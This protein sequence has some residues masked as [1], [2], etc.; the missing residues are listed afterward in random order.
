MP[1]EAC[2]SGSDSSEDRSFS[3]P[4]INLSTADSKPSKPKGR[5]GWPEHVWAAELKS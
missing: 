5:T 3:P 1:T 2:C 4:E